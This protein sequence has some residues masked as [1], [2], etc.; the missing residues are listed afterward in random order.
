[1]ANEE[2]PLSINFDHLGLQLS[3]PGD[4]VGEGAYTRLL[5]LTSFK[6]GYLQV[7]PGSSKVYGAP[8]SA[9]VHSMGRMLLAGIGK[10]YEGAGTALY[11]NGT[12][13][14]TGFSGNPITFEA[15]QI[16]SS[17]APYMVAFDRT[18]RVKDSGTAVSPFGIATPA[19]AAIAVAATALNKTVDTFDSATGWSGTD[20]TVALDT[21][22]KKE[23]TGSIKVTVPA[24]KE[25]TASKSSP[26]DLS[27]F[28]IAGD[29][30]PEDYLHFWI[31][32]DYPDR[33]TEIRIMLDC[34]PSVNDFTRNYYF[35]SLQPSSIQKVVIGVDTSQQGSYQQINQGMYGDPDLIPDY[36]Q[37]QY[38]GVEL[39]TGEGQWTEFL[40]KKSE[41]VRVG[42]HS[43]T[44]ANIAAIG[45]W[46]KTNQTG[47][48]IVN[49]D[50]GY[51]TGGSSLKLDGDY[52]W[53]YV[54]RNN[55]T[56]VT[57]PISPIMGAQVSIN[58]T[59][60]TVT[61]QNT[62]DA[63]VGKIDLYRRGGT[64]TTTFYFVKTVDNNPAG[65]TQDISD[66]VA[67]R[68][69]GEKIETTLLTAIECPTTSRYMA[70]HAGRAW[71]TDPNYPDRLWY[72]ELYKIESFNS[73]YYIPVSQGGE[74]VQRPYELEDQLFVFTNKSPYR[75]I[76]TSETSFMAIPTGLERGLFSC[77]AICRGKASI[78]FRAYDGIYAFTGSANQLYK[79]SDNIDPL[80][81]GLTV[82]GRYP[83]DHA[84][85]AG[86]RLEYWDD[87][88]HYSYTDTIAVRREMIFDLETKRWE[89]TDRAPTSYL[90]LDDAKQFRA[91]D[92]AGYVWLRE[93][94][95]SDD[96]APINFSFRTGYH[97]LGLPAHE[98][99]WKELTIDADPDGATLTVKAIFD[100]GTSEATLGTITGA[101]RT[102][103]A[104]PINN[105][106][107]TKARN[108]AVE[109]IDNNE[110]HV[111]KFYKAH[112]G[113]LVEPIETLK[114]ITDWEDCTDQGR[115]IFRQLLLDIDNQGQAVTCKAYI[116]TMTS[117][118]V[119]ATVAASLARKI[120]PIDIGEDKEGRLVRF[121]V[122]ATTTTPFK[123]HSHKWDF[124]PQHCAEASFYQTDWNSVGFLG[125]KVFK[126][127]NFEIDTNGSNVVGTVEFDDG[128]EQEF[129]CCSNYRTR[130]TRSFTIDTCKTLARLKFQSMAV[131]TSVASPISRGMQTVTPSSMTGIKIGSDL[132]IG[133][134]DVVSVLDVSPTT[135]TAS[136]PNDYGAPVTVT[137]DGNDFLLYDQTPSFDAE[138]YGLDATYVQTPWSTDGQTEAKIYRQ[139]HIRLSTD[140]TVAVAVDI[141]GAA[142]HTFTGVLA[143][144][145]NKE[146]VLS[147]PVDTRGYQSRV[148][149]FMETASTGPFSYLG[150]NWDLLPDSSGV[151]T[152]QTAWSDLG[153]PL[154]K[155]LRVICLDVDTG[156]QNVIVTVG[157][158]GVDLP[159]TFTLNTAT[160]SE[161]Y[162]TLPFDT[163]GKLL[164]LKMAA[165]TA[166]PLRYYSHRVDSL[167][168]TYFVTKLQ[169]ALEDSGTPEE[170]LYRTLI[171][172]IDTV[173]VSTTVTPEIDGA[174][175]TPLSVTANGRGEKL[176]AVPFDTR[177]KLSRLKIECSSGFRYFGHRWDMIP[178]VALRTKFQTEY[179]DGG[180][181]N[182]K[183]FRLLVID[184]DTASNPTNIYVDF[185]GVEFG[186]Y[187]TATTTTRE[188]LFFVL[189]YDTRGQQSRLRI[190]GSGSGFRYYGHRWDNL[191]DLTANP[192]RL[193][194]AWHDSG[195]PG[196]KIYRTLTLDIDTLT[197]GNSILV[198]PEIDGVAY[199]PFTVSNATR[200]E[201]H[202]SMPHDTFGSL[203]RLKIEA[204]PGSSFRYYGHR[205]DSLGD[206][207]LISK[208]QTEW[209]DY[210][211]SEEKIFRVLCLEINTSSQNV[212]ATV[213]IDGVAVAPTFTVN[214]S[215]RRTEFLCLP[216]DTRGKL[217]RIKLSSAGQFRYYSH[218]WNSLGDLGEVTRLQTA[219]DNSGSDLEKYYRVIALDINTEAGATS[220]TV[221]IDG[222]DLVGAFGVVTAARQ[223]EYLA[224]PF[225]TRGRLSRLKIECATGF[226]YY[227]HKVDSL[228]QTHY[229]KR[230]Q[231][232]WQNLD[233]A[234]D[235]FLRNLILDVDTASSELTIT[236]E[237]D[238]VDL[239][240]LTVTNTERKEE[241][242]ALPF[243][244]RGKLVRLK[245]ESLLGSF[246]YYGHQFDALA[247]VAT[248]KK[249]QTEWSDCGTPLEKFF[250]VI[251]LEIDTLGNAATVTVGVDGADLPSTFSV[252]TL[253]RK[254]EYLALPFDT[255]GKVV[256]L[257]M[258]STTGFRYYGHKW[259][260]LDETHFVTKL[261]TAWDDSGNPEEKLYRNLVLVFDS[262]GASV[263][264]TPEIDGAALTPLTTSATG[265]QEKHLAMPYDT[266]G[267]LSRLKLECA[268][269]L[270][271]FGHRWD[272]LGDV[273]SVTKTYTEWTD[274][275]DPNDKF[276]RNLILNI[277]PQGV[278]ATVTVEIDGVALAPTFSVTATGR[279]E[280]FLALPFDQR[281]QIS[282]L[283]IES[284]TGFRYYGHKWDFLGDLSSVTRLQTAWHD[285]GVPG[286]KLHRELVLEI[287]TGGIAATVTPEIDGVALSPFSVTASG[288][289]QRYLSLPFDTRGRLSRLKIES[290]SRFR[291]Y[292]H[293]WDHL[294]DASSITKFQTE[295]SDYGTAEQ[296]IFR[297]LTLDIDTQSALATVTVE[298][299]GTAV[300]PSFS[301]TNT[302][303]TEEHLCLPYDTRGK[304]GRIK[305]ESTTGFR[306]YTHK[307]NS[308]EDQAPLT[309]IATAWDNSGTDLEKFY[310]TLVVELDTQ[311]VAATVTPEID[312]V[313]L[314]AFTVN[315]AGRRESYL[316][317]PF[318]TRGRLSRIKVACATGFRFYGHKWDNLKDTTAVTKFHTEWTD[319]GKS[320]PKFFLTMPIEID[321]GGANVTATVEIDGASAGTWTINTVT[322][323]KE[324]L[325][326]NKDTKGTVCRLKLE[327]ATATPFRYYGH[328]FDALDEPN[329]LGK[330]Q[331]P[332]SV[333]GYPGD[334]RFRQL[335]LEV[336]T[337]SADLTVNVEID[338]VTAKTFTVNTSGHR[339]KILS[340]NK[341]TIGKIARL[342]FS[343]ATDFTYYTHSFDFVPDPLDVTFFDTFDL[344]FNYDRWKFIRRAWIAAQ[345]SAQVTMKV[346]VDE[347]LK[348]TQY[349]T[350]NPASGWARN[351]IV[352]PPNLKGQLFRFTFESA[353]AFKL[354]LDQSRVEWHPLNGERGYQRASLVRAS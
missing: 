258:E 78:F 178:D 193:Q 235:K 330:Y 198:T 287:D 219:W 108:F 119:T 42:S 134:T 72:S 90:R 260:N 33:L 128:S 314:A 291:Y 151:T 268:T 281:G 159:G 5:N 224:L 114:Y 64:L 140:S 250:R 326:F 308:L 246:R 117:P 189:P 329:A 35:K 87:R 32:A 348:T 89:P 152:M 53:I 245:M 325:A 272:A 14:A 105:G 62:T 156:G 121:L 163:R 123:Y 118:V 279:D 192:N 282:R 55:S 21:T 56:N 71:V 187:F 20:C 185:D 202:L 274:S 51:M 150:H 122:E 34:D 2:K 30:D 300:V 342:T 209:S 158:D 58:K 107:G 292:G 234:E 171:L 38:E 204:V 170:K 306:Y 125:L 206:V 334:K 259:D 160:R 278:A 218:R 142:V 104:L 102:T 223:I 143:S 343:S 4:L 83:I 190:V 172:D 228:E 305:I 97:D 333:Y 290:A 284:A 236:P 148:R 197:L 200:T 354:F 207:P 106:L 164:R 215:A 92:S 232:A 244:T 301:V 139:L 80:F 267:K 101:G 194:T 210:G 253:G 127:V 26:L 239:T 319:L 322:R 95:S 261:Q 40:V 285:S 149:V 345:G 131:N 231:T 349:F 323:L 22:E 130:I 91:G 214:N 230:L 256:R 188:E 275:G 265:R 124:I 138:P 183:F 286:D 350:S 36:G 339:Q 271:Y 174:A 351:P 81:H 73:T 99:L 304:L 203:S 75:I 44:W 141:D 65:G 191:Q 180:N 196:Q 146:L 165:A 6:R 116:D 336:D 227:G 155:Y 39:V 252:T 129:G 176:L 240:A 167:E 226:R 12:E 288:R 237:V 137:K 60:A 344:D 115:K 37:G 307:W 76:G 208:Y 98:K 205:W 335:I 195:Q 46:I 77:N 68:A 213:E 262:A 47:E 16:G 352:M 173:N 113:F 263:T 294:V 269:G 54:H 184:I 133:G 132:L 254:E 162:L 220:V 341:D 346:Y 289:L 248:R 88:L 82:E 103:Y 17:T 243:D 315:T 179:T 201:M 45:L 11:R 264:V 50:D 353:S 340:L 217:A 61:V 249:F 266:R 257:K 27:K 74:E 299:D 23:G 86:E 18:K 157:L 126:Q 57:S 233:T 31:R 109:V 135:F 63:Q 153:S 216:F 296:K 181:P 145:L 293:R 320:N 169:T 270:R 327:S 276:Y 277:D 15:Y 29:S 111:C 298:I 324:I 247:D 66:G 177:G 144:G 303:R 94:G 225:D 10:T 24:S 229:V 19:T 9:A 112:V 317:L 154:E 221:G 242:I 8:L 280:Q 331:T 338:G 100:N 186:S 211:T 136:F 316:S 147:L 318:D 7:R 25:G 328:T 28:T 337:A 166:T 1:M 222:S 67:D 59:G 313:A 93:T 297:V 273:A 255:R 241:I 41:F 168:Q 13:I 182:E 48:T 120:E 175:L 295:W 238:G 321:T 347:E 311:G 43:N 96:S 310:R 85:A 161:Q 79:L 70:I 3:I 309:Q 312:G 251:C 52:D 49:I 283:K 332:W 84:Q 69:L 212:T 199:S 110:S 302:G